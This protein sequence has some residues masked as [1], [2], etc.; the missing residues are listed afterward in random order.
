MPRTTPEQVA[1]HRVMSVEEML[2]CVCTFDEQASAPVSSL[3]E[4]GEGVVERA[5]IGKA[6]PAENIDAGKLAWPHGFHVRRLDLAPGGALDRH[7][8][9]EEEVVYVHR[10]QLAYEWDQQELVL[11]AGDVLTVPIGLAHGF[12]NASDEPAV[13]YVVRG[14][15]APS[16]PQWV[17]NKS[18]RS[19]R[20]AG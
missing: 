13:V 12:R 18:S 15:D 2:A 19:N 1:A 8:R 11:E 9:S 7:S 16:A 3:G 10:G 5:I 6:N 14:G 17:V 20:M 4:A